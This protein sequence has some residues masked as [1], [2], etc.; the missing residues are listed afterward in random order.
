MK[1]CSMFPFASHGGHSARVKMRLLVGQLSIPVAQMGPD[2]VLLESPFNHPPAP[3]SVELQVDQSKR[4]WNV[5]LPH[6]IS[7][8]TKRVAIAA[9]A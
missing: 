5:H 2:F 8:D 3:A 6:G 9:G 7:A 4:S 1:S